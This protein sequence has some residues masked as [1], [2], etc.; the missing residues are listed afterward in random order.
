M[1]ID[2]MAL[3]VSSENYQGRLVAVKPVYG[4]G[5]YRLDAPEIPVPAEVNGVPRPFHCRIQHF[6]YFQNELRGALAVI[7]ELSHI[8]DGLWVVF[9]PRVI[10]THDFVNYLPYCDIQIG[11][12]APVGEWPEFLSGSPI[13]SGY[14]FV[15]ES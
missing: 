9:S 3:D 4:W 7:E 8:Y 2:F 1:K 13:V 12:D 10:G 14:G 15:G 6:F 11:T 5:W